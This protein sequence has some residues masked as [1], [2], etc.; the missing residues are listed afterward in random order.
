MPTFTYPMIFILNEDTELYN[1]YIPDLLLYCDG[2]TLESV[3]ATA[4]ELINYYFEL[5]TK[6]DTEIPQP[7]T[8]EEVSKKWTG[9]KVS[10]ITA[11][12]KGKS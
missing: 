1:G 2:E 5:A 9:Y 3:Y 7:S 11:E 12:I 10:L 8:L 6:Y 4:R